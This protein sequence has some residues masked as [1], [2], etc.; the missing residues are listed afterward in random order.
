L[1]YITIILG[2]SGS[3]AKINFEKI[4][5]KLILKKNNGGKNINFFESLGRTLRGKEK[6]EREGEGERRRKPPGTW[7]GP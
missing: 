7:P 2:W 5:Q 1:Q 4:L 6:G 3:I